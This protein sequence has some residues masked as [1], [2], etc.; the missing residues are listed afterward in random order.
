M[1]AVARLTAISRRDECQCGTNKS[2]TG[3]LALLRACAFTLAKHLAETERSHFE[4]NNEREASGW[5]IGRNQAEL[6][7]HRAHLH[8]PVA[9]A[10]SETVN[11]TLGESIKRKLRQ[12]ETALGTHGRSREANASKSLI[13]RVPH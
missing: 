6:A 7:F 9:S 13:C 1:D 12:A 3:T 10:K 11:Q 5:K 4:G 8:S 2:L